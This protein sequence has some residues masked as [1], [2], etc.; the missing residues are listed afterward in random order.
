MKISSLSLI[1]V[2]ALGFSLASTLSVATEDVVVRTPSAL[3][4]N[5]VTT[6]SPNYDEHYTD[7]QP[8][9]GKDRAPASETPPTEKA[10][11][12]EAAAPDSKPADGAAQPAT[13]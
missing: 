13:P 4:R 12:D 11:L 2:S 10:P 6:D 9:E 7:D 3:N 1:V 8:N 5:L